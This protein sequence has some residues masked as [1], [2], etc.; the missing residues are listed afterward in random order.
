[1]TA[2]LALAASALVAVPMPA[3]A[4]AVSLAQAQATRNVNEVGPATCT[5]TNGGSA[6]V[7][8]FASNGVT[9]TQTASGT[10][11]L[12]DNGD[13][14]DTT[15]LPST[16]TTR[17]RAIEAGG[18]LKTLDVDSTFTGK[19][20]SAQGSATD[21]DA[22]VQLTSQASFQTVLTADRWLTLDADIPP[23]GTGQVLFQRTA[24]TSP[25]VFSVVALVGN[26]KGHA[27]AEVF[28]PAGTY[29]AQAFVAMSWDGPQV[30]SD[31]TSFTDTGFVHIVFEAA[32]AAK[33]KAAGDG[34]AYARLKDGRDCA[35]GRLTGKFLKAAGTKTKPALKKAVFKV[36]GTKSK[37]VKKAKK[38]GKITL[39]N[40]PAGEDVSVKAVFK[41][42]GG[43][44]ESFT[45]D[46]YSCT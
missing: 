24:P 27:R 1:M 35:T 18:Q 14:G 26:A 5:V 2:G 10:T 32:G 7:A 22:E 19:V 9:V 31:P 23:G 36:N 30:A 17:V 8:P 38:G 3:Q 13:A 16:V 41:L 25:P 33:A 43:G 6:T 12:V 34:A 37:V 40:L 29:Q 4:A 28:L 42:V 20:T 11:T 39:K 45:R 44:S 46:Y 21:C 15:S